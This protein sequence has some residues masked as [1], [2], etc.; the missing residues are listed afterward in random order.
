MNS[1][2]IGIP[3]NLAN[4]LAKFWRT[5]L[6]RSSTKQPSKGLNARREES[7]K[8]KINCYKGVYLEASCPVIDFPAQG[9]ELSLSMNVFFIRCDSGL[10]R[11]EPQADRIPFLRG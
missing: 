9:V 5:G 10:L 8:V 4:T 11:P 6:E 3:Q 7:P 2:S 1:M